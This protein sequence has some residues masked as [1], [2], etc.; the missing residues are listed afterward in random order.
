MDWEQEERADYWVIRWLSQIDWSWKEEV[1][2]Q[3]IG[4]PQEQQMSQA[5]NK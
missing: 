3:S 5:I 2:G 1:K 4:G